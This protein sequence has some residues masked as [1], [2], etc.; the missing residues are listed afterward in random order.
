MPW[1]SR[2]FDF[3]SG[4]FGLILYKNGISR[5]FEANNS[6]I[7]PKKSIITAKKRIKEINVDNWKENRE[8]GNGEEKKW[9]I[10]KGKGVDN[11]IF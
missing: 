9:K 2:A 7:W 8:K 5:K 10:G 4:F 3:K 1:I 6:P 11:E